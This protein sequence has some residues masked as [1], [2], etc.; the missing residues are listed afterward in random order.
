MNW[1]VS[2]TYII[3]KQ[4]IA[5]IRIGDTINSAN[6]NIIGNV[7]GCINTFIDNKSRDFFYG[8]NTELE[9]NF[10][11]EGFL[12]IEEEKKNSFLTV[13]NNT[14]LE[15]VAVNFLTTNDDKLLLVE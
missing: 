5:I 1:N 12:D 3:D 8:L 13:I 7:I 9:N 14:K 15:Q 6:I 11:Y 4:Y 2:D 10:R